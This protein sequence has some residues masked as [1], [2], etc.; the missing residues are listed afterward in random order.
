[1][2]MKV[3]A[4][5]VNVR[6]FD[7]IVPPK[8]TNTRLMIRPEGSRDTGK[9]ILRKHRLGIVLLRRGKSTAVR[10]LTYGR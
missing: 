8:K 10:M 7:L 6:E 9:I 4:Q 1:M 3:F 2:D 5:I